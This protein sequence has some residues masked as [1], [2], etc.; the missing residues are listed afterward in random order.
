MVTNV[1]DIWFNWWHNNTIVFSKR[2]RLNR[3]NQILNC[4]HFVNVQVF[5]V[6]TI[7]TWQLMIFIWMSRE[8]TC[9]L[10]LIPN[11]W[12]Q[13]TE[14]MGPTIRIYRAQC[15]LCTICIRS[16]DI[17]TITLFLYKLFKL[18]FIAFGTEENCSRNNNIIK[19]QD[20]RAHIYACSIQTPYTITVLCSWIACVTFLFFVDINKRTCMQI[21]AWNI[22]CVWTTGIRL[23]FQ[24]SVSLVGMQ[25][26]FADTTM[27][28][29]HL[30]SE[31]NWVGVKFVFRDLHL[32]TY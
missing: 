4:H 25:F 12:Q 30:L 2:T 23:G 11:C 28:Y 19:Y 6:A 8:N 14:F 9:I 16:F 20:S 3:T 27:P 31:L 29:Y 18:V 13:V 21:T 1:G 7:Q 17:Y 10:L 26:L 24:I 22:A 32:L 5:L 15:Y